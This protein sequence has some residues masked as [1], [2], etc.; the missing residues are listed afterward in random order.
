[1]TPENAIKKEK[2]IEMSLVCP[3]DEFCSL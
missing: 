3:I 1:M 2:F